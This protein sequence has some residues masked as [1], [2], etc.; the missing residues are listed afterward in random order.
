MKRLL[1][2][3]IFALSLT[4]CATTPSFAVD[5]FTVNTIDVIEIEVG[6]PLPKLPDG[7]TILVTRWDLISA[8]FRA[9]FENHYPDYCIYSSDSPFRDVVLGSTDPNTTAVIAWAKTV[10]LIQGDGD[11]NFRPD[12]PITWRELCRF[13]TRFY[14]I[15]LITDETAIDPDGRIAIKSV[16]DRLNRGLERPEPSR[17]PGNFVNYSEAA[18]VFE[19]FAAV[20]FQ[21]LITLSGM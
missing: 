18:K 5:G 21:P 6:R 4:L 16:E 20:G 13:V 14:G 9:K 19:S 15:S 7:S 8:V 12:D 3:L 11:G 2:F 10:G 17:P 1:P